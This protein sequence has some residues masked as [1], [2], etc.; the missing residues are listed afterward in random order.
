[1]S[2]RYQYIVDLEAGTDKFNKQT[3]GA[4]KM[5]KGLGAAAVAAAAI[6]GFQKVGQVAMDLAKAA[7]TQMRAEAKIEQAIRSTAGAA[8][9]SAAELKNMASEL[10]NVTLFGD[11]QIMKDVTSQLLTF[12]NVSGES[13]ARAQQAA[14]D[15]ATVLDGDLKGASLQLGKA[16][17][18]PVQGI[19]A[20]SRAGI[21]FSDG[22]KATIKMLTETNRMAEAQALILDEL[23]VQFGGQAKAAA[24]AG[25]GPWI[26]WQN[27]LGDVKEYL[28]GFI[29][30]YVNK[31][32]KLLSS[33]FNP[34]NFEAF[35]KK[36]IDIANWFVEL[37]NESMVVRYAVNALGMVFKNAFAVAIGIVKE[38]W[39]R[40]K[41]VGSII[42]AVLTGNFKEI[43]DIMKA[44]MEKSVEL[45][46]ETATKV[47]DNYKK[48]FEN[49]VRGKIEYIEP[50]RAVEQATEAGGKAAQAFYEETRKAPAA[51]EP[52]KIP[53]AYD[54]E[55]PDNLFGPNTDYGQMNALSAST[56]VLEEQFRKAEQTALLFGDAQSL[57]ADKAA[58]LQGEIANLVDQGFDA[59][60]TA[61]QG[62]LDMYG[63]LFVAQSALQEANMQLAESLEQTA[64]SGADSF[65][66]LARSML[67][68][69][70]SVIA[71]LISKGVAAAVSSALSGA[72]YPLN[73][74][75][76]PAAG[77]VAATAFNSLIP[78]FAD[79]GLVYGPTMGLMGEYAGA[80]SNP[81][82]IA[83][84]DKLRG[85]IR[86]ERGGGFG[87]DVRFIIEGD[88]LKGVLNNYDRKQN[89][90]G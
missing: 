24:E 38:L 13:F 47:G 83:P 62:L 52:M 33:V 20:L 59:N 74:F 21:Q 69:V 72:P 77:A 1:M 9:Y 84:L 4:S 14:L 81:E 41:G 76:A 12:T 60:S 45:A 89:R 44:Q 55:L 75:L 23:N 70:R 6:K 53:A 64:L 54:V 68:S 67:N 73:L 25:M 51:L 78:Q 86:E 39:N 66:D 15:M 87:G 17:N 2:K 57:A 35:R 42:K 90:I 10:Q 3:S 65:Q 58:L 16:L 8:G 49:T 31:L 40:I 22:Q 36:L 26:Q 48:A 18:D 11:E 27:T 30:P 19:T 79:G 29:V 80:K 61:V 46:T 85:M 71:G 5:L 28:G 82:V 88:R 50:E 63:E 43:P 34:S 56:A 7:D 32:G 37:Y